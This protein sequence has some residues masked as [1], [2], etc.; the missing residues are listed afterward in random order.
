MADKQTTIARRRWENIDRHITIIFLLFPLFLFLFLFVFFLFRLYPPV[1]FFR[2]GFSESRCILREVIKYP[3]LS[4]FLKSNLRPK[5]DVRVFSFF[6]AVLLKTSYLSS[7]F[8]LLFLLITTLTITVITISCIV[9]IIT[10]NLLKGG[11][12]KN[13][14]PVSETEDETWSA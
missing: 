5:I 13:F 12:N 8:S 11:K 3:G 10:I 2:P 1:F 9:K 4:N 7:S 14:P 6:C